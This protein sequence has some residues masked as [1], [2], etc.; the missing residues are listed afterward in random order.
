MLN[1]FFH[2]KVE[3]DIAKDS[4][5]SVEESYQTRVDEDQLEPLKE[6]IM[7]GGNVLLSSA[8]VIVCMAISHFREA[9]L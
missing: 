6:F 2:F 3:S 7:L 4:C 5:Q 8:F 1:D 9:Q